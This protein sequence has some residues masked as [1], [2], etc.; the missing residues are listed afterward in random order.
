[1]VARRRLKTR[2]RLL[3]PAAAPAGRLALFGPPPLLDGED[4]ALYDELLARV[5][6][7]VKPVD[8]IEEM[9]V[10]DIIL[11]QWEIMRWHRLKTNLL[12]RSGQKA[13]E[14]HLNQ[15]LDF[16]LYAKVFVEDLAEILQKQNLPEDQAQEL[17]YQCALA[18]SGAEEKVMELLD[19]AGPSIDS[20]Q[21]LAMAKRVKGLAQEYARREPDA[22]E[23]VN[24]LLASGGLTM[25][26]IMAEGLTEKFN[27]IERI[28]QLIT[29][30]ETRRN[31]S[32][33][34]IDRRRAVLGGALR[35]TVQDVEDAEFEVIDTTRAKGKS[36][37]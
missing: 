14:N 3:T 36:A 18:E 6:A 20:I 9:F 15:M 16:D 25:Y 31:A 26:D 17:A 1:M 34:E 21:D 37:A 32:L 4:A 19:P 28:D 12:R 11:L 30:V 24:R 33:R 27:E 2:Q 22:I 23:H 7:A 29:I 10:A 8:I 5:C 13:L 35:R